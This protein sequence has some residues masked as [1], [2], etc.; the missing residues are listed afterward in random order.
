[1]ARKCITTDDS[2]SLG[3]VDCILA[4]GYRI[5]KYLPLGTISRAWVAKYLKRMKNFVQLNW[6]RLS[7]ECAMDTHWTV[8]LR[9]LLF[10]KNQ[11]ANFCYHPL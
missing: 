5:V 4:I 7:Y 3:F 2:K 1:M 6:N 8:Q 11:I 9:N 10:L